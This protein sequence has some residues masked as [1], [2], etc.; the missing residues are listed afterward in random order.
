MA[1]HYTVQQVAIETLP[2]THVLQPLPSACAPICHLAYCFSRPDQAYAIQHFDEVEEIPDIPANNM[3][4]QRME[5]T[6]S[7]WCHTMILKLAQHSGVLIYCKQGCGQESNNSISSP[8]EVTRGIIDVQDF[9]N[10]AT[11][12]LKCL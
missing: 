1:A 10:P 2:S 9:W 11:C 6:F 12:N 3:W 5:N 7:D 8:R 4:M